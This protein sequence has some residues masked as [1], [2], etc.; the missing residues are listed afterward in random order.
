MQMDQSWYSHPCIRVSLSKNR[1]VQKSYLA[2]F[3]LNL[4]VTFLGW[5]F[6]TLSKDKGIVGDLLMESKGHGSL[7]SPASRVHV[8]IRFTKTTENN[9]ERSTQRVVRKTKRPERP[10]YLLGVLKVEDYTPKN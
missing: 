5:F 10:G 6:V 7:E 3:S 4:L 9:D 2:D 1:M 8:L